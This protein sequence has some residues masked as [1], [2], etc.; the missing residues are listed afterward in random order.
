MARLRLRSLQGIWSYLCRDVADAPLKPLSPDRIMFNLRE[1]RRERTQ[2]V[3]YQS[4]SQTVYHE[5]LDVGVGF[6]SPLH[7]KYDHEFSVRTQKMM[8]VTRKQMGRLRE[9]GT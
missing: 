4:P 2:D 3:R 5:L 6:V 8:A 1:P 9:E 7:A